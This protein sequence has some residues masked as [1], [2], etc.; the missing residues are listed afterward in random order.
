MTTEMTWRKKTILLTGAAGVV[1]RALIDEL[2]PDFDIVCM[3]HRTPV[4][5][6]R[7]SE[8]GGSFDEPRLGMSADD[9]AVLVRRVD[10]IVHA[11]AAT[12]WKED[13]A[14][15]REVNLGGPTALLRLAEQAS[16]PLYFLSTAFVANPP[17]ANGHSPGAA[18]YVHSKIEAEELVRSHPAASVILRPSIITGD[19]VDGRM[20]QFQG[21]HA[22]LGAIVRG[23]APMIPMPA[24]ALIDFVPQDLVAAV[25]GKLLREGVETGEF[26][27]TAGD[28]SLNARDIMD[29]CMGLA[30]ELGL[31]TKEPRLIPTEAVDRLIIPLLE[32]S[33][34][35]KLAA[36]FRD[37]LEFS[38]LFQSAEPLPNSLPELGFGKQIEKD[39]LHRAAYNSMY[40]WARVKGL[41]PADGKVRVA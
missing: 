6:V 38:W 1:G 30:A 7:V 12:S 32:D 37:L 20:S 36:K 21:I 14:R 9:Y 27:L 16:V 33:L 34:P 2:A 35:P 40:Y 31:A 4:A 41:A 28:Q 26:W 29:L 5:D 3:R 39:A 25:I 15:I 24:D 18:A 8:F 17:A 23:A 22:V 19:S 10:A 13:P 11:A